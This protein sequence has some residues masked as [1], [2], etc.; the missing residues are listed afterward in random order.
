MHKLLQIKDTVW[1]K[2]KQEVT[3]GRAFEIT[4]D[5]EFRAVPLT[6]LYSLCETVYNKI[7]EA[8]EAED[9]ETVKREIA[10]LEED[11]IWPEVTKLF[12]PAVG[13][14]LKVSKKTQSWKIGRARINN[15]RYNTYDFTHQ[16]SI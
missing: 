8:I 7:V 16:L 5:Y 15:D 12:G 9:Q 6:V 3:I 4:Y 13:K 10:N 14:S 11:L 1:I 2:T